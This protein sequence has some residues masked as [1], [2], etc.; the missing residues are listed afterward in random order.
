MQDYL[1]QWRPAAKLKK[2]EHLKSADGVIAVADGGVT[3][4]VHDGWMWDLTIPGNN[5]HDFYVLEVEASVHDTLGTGAPILVHNDSCPAAAGEV[6]ALPAA[7]ERL[8][9]QAGDH[10]PYMDAPIRSF[11]TAEDQTYYRVFSGDRNVGS[12]LTGA[13][14]ASADRAVA[15]PA[16]PP[17][18]TAEFI[19]EVMVPA[20]TRLQSS[21]ASPAFGQPG[22][23]LQFEL[24]ERIPIKNFGEGVPF[25]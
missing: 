4:K 16:L 23:M 15:G 5:D 2:G 11:V 22:G 14:S 9:L 6:P 25:G 12:F 19:Q 20:G 1:K 21:I 17:A 18:N 3:P 7:P 8:A 10:V 24:L 13:P